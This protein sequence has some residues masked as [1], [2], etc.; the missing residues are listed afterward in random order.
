MTTAP[1]SWVCYFYQKIRG[2]LFPLDHP[3]R[4][5]AQTVPK[6]G[7]CG[8]W[9]LLERKPIFAGNAQ[10]NVQKNSTDVPNCVKEAKNW[11]WQIHL[12]TPKSL[13]FLI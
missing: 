3:L 9:H 8:Q 1:Q 5:L 4:F 7:L 2:L 6:P 11:E 10:G 12:S 13:R